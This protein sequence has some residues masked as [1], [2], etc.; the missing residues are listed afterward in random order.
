MVVLLG[1]LVVPSGLVVEG[2]V[3]VTLRRANV[4]LL[5]VIAVLCNLAVVS[6]LAQP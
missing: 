5:I 2:L 3:V 1:L 6:L 4:L